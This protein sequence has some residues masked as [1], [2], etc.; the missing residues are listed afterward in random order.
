MRLCV[1]ANSNRNNVRSVHVESDRFVK[2]IPH[3]F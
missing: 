3:I 2:H 1:E